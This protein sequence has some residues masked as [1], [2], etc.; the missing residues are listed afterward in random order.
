LLPAEKL[1][2]I[3]LDECLNSILKV[4]NGGVQLTSLSR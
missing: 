4:G 1:A 2:V 3:T